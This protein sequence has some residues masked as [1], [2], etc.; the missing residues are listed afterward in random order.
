V[1]EHGYVCQQE[2]D[3]QKRERG[4]RTGRSSRSIRKQVVLQDVECKVLRNFTGAVSERAGERATL[5][6]V[7][8]RAR[9]RERERERERRR[10]RERESESESERVSERDREAAP[11]SHQS[12]MPFCNTR[13]I[14]CNTQTGKIWKKKMTPLHS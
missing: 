10:E 1:S 13:S 7:R 9:A 6:H 11:H 3:R 2:K 12:G 14:F 5:R 4:R 8:E